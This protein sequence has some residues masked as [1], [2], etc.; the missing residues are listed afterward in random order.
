MARIIAFDYGKRRIGIAVSDPMQIIAT[1][2]T[3]VENPNANK[4]TNRKEFSKLK[5]KYAIK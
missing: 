4:T 1:G 5:A 3:T 2:L